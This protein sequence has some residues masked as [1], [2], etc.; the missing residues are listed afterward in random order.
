MTVHDEYNF[1]FPDPIKPRA[2]ASDS[3]DWIWLAGRLVAFV[4]VVVLAI[5]VGVSL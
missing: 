5:K 4:A 2:P 3:A 1:K